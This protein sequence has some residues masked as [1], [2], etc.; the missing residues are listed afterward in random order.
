MSAERTQSSPRV[1]RANHR[2]RSCPMLAVERRRPRR[3]EPAGCRILGIVEPETNVERVNWREGRVG[4]EAEDVV[5]QDGSDDNVHRAFVV[6]LEVRL[7]PSQTEV[8][9]I[10]V[11][12]SVRQQIAA[13]DGEEI[14]LEARLN[15]LS[16]QGEG[17]VEGAAHHGHLRRR[18][19]ACIAGE[20]REATQKSWIGMQVEM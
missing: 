18:R 20:S 12:G 8:E 3:V 5:E 11:H 1:G 15:V 6:G 19:M 14:E 13:L 9:K 7:V 10:W 17:V 2:V 16:A 4:I